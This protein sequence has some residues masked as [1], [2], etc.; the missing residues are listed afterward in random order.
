MSKPTAAVNAVLL[1]FDQ[2]S[3]HN[4]E[5][6]SYGGR[7][8]AALAQVMIQAF[9]LAA[10]DKRHRY[11]LNPR[12]NGIELRGWPPKHF[13]ERSISGAIGVWPIVVSGEFEPNRS[14]DPVVSR[15][16]VAGDLETLKTTDDQ[17]L[18]CDHG[19]PVLHGISD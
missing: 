4:V 17:S 10:R 16:F 14:A 1:P 18:D 2:G 13:Q 15:T 12:Q 5:P 6:T 19:V 3:A 8:V 11:R 7:M 9:P